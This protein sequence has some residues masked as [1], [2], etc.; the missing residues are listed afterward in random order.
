MS[1]LDSLIVELLVLTVVGL[2]AVWPSVASVGRSARRAFTPWSGWWQGQ[3]SGEEMKLDL[4][5]VDEDILQGSSLDVRP[6]DEE[7]KAK[8]KPAP[9]APVAPKMAKPRPSDDTSASSGDSPII[10][11]AL[12]AAEMF[13]ADLKQA[14]KMSQSLVINSALLAAQMFQQDL[15]KAQKM[16][17]A[18]S[19]GC[20]DYISI[21][22]EK[23]HYFRVDLARAQAQAVIKQYY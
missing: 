22:L 13:Q 16:S 19:A 15:K 21:A 4:D 6:L 2:P 12:V 7:T 3:Q 9:Q 20:G 5:L 1:I 8:A 10:S 14:Q 23:A 17:S 18:A 11:S